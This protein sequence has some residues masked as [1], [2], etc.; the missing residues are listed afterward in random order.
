MESPQ[1]LF[2]EL[3]GLARNLDVLAK[4]IRESNKINSE[5][6]KTQAKAVENS[7]KKE[8][9]SA[10]KTTV[11]SKQTSSSTS[12]P[13]KNPESSSSG[14]VGRTS[15]RAG[16]GALKAAG[17]SFLKGGSIKDIAFAGLKGGISEGKKSMVNEAIGGVSTIQTRREEL[18]NKEKPFPETKEDKKESVLDKLNPFKSRA[19]GEDKGSESP[20][21]KAEENKGFFG[22]LLDRINSKKEE[23]KKEESRGGEE[24]KSE[25]PKKEGKRGFFGSLLDRLKPK[26]EPTETKSPEAAKADSSPKTLESKSTV[27]GE[28]KKAYEGSTLGKIVAE[29]K[30]LS[31]KIKERREG[32]SEMKKEEQTLKSESP[33]GAKT[34]PASEKEKS[35]SETSP[36]GTSKG[37]SPTDSSKSAS[38]GSASSPSDS[39]SSGTS[40]PKS[41]E[42]GISPQDIQDI[43]SLLSAIN[44]TLNGPLTVKDN[45]PF[46]PK[47]SMLE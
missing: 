37:A 7:V 33:K 38:S 17:M 1:K 13:K 11:E 22:K 42:Q 36:D 35:K 34:P 4:E 3:S 32:K 10:K 39:K 12:S 25:I 2:Q 14:A 9:E 29:G 23:G 21:T 46:R 40:N 24:S 8:T 18:K 5:S 26:E 19:K 6:Q 47:S 27:K 41:A 45:K 31:K 30:S 15:K 20:A 44:T 16:L 43:K 28:L